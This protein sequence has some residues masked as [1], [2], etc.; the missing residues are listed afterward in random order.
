MR[1]LNVINRYLILAEYLFIYIYILFFI[2]FVG[3][4]RGKLMGSQFKQKYTTS[5]RFTKDGVLIY[6]N[7]LL[8]LLRSVSQ[9]KG[10]TWVQID[11]NKLVHVCNRNTVK[12]RRCIFC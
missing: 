5:G 4:E 6:Q 10:F 11:A 3:I 8:L 9:S 7:R 2:E 12:Y 1:N